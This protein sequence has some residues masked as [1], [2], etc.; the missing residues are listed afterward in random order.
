MRENGEL[1]VAENVFLRV[2]LDASALISHVNEH[3][4]AH[5]AVRGD[6]A[7][8]GHAMAFRQRAGIEAAAGG[9]AFGVRRK[10]VL[11]RV[12][13]LGAQ[14][15]EFFS[16]LLD[17]RILVHGLGRWRSCRFGFHKNTAVIKA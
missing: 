14:G 3:G 1:V 13:A 2:A 12:N 17:E 10:F 6:A 5:V 9:I 7:S 16:A 15:V 11:K 8:D 4:F